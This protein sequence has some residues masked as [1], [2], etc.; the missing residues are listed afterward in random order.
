[1]CEPHIRADPGNMTTMTDHAVRP[2][3]NVRYLY[4]RRLTVA[5]LAAAALLVTVGST[6]PASGSVGESVHC[7]GAAARDRAHPCT[8]RTLS[9]VPTPHLAE[10]APNAP[11]KRVPRT[12]GPSV[13]TFGGPALGAA[14]HIALLG[15]SHASHWRAAV[16]VVAWA[17]RWHGFSLTRSSCS[18]S[19]AIKVLREP[20]GSQCTS[21]NK[22]V[23]AW[24]RSHPE[25]ST[26]FVSQ[27]TDPTVVVSPGHTRF[28][29]QVAGYMGAWRALPNT[30]KHIVVIRDTPVNMPKTI[31]CVRRAI[32]RH[33]RAG[34]V[35]AVPRSMA[36]KRDSAISAVARLRSRRYEAVDLT[37]FFCGR[38]L[39]YPVIGGVLVRSDVDHV[40]PL[41]AATLWP[42]L[43]GK[44][45]RLMA[46]W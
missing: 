15:D 40:T 1:M 2:R 18:F 42:F 31:D 19:T 22:S 10:V 38:R 36:L 14:G 33:K 23:L 46:S 39:C 44:L 24:F 8:N 35:C 26:V 12:A 16:N 41:F 43:L 5:G 13:C 21:W 7:F 9:V 3:R 27:H 20:F 34:V 11:C 29:A 37:E 4:G 17:K 28:G 25:I 30:V 32:V 45:D 6:V